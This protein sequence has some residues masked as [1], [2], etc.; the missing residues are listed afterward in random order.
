MASIRVRIGIVVGAVVNR[1][2]TDGSKKEFTSQPAEDKIKP[3]I[4]S[5]EQVRSLP[6]LGWRPL[7]HNT[8]MIPFCGTR[9][10]PSRCSETGLHAR[11]ESGWMLNVPYAG[12]EGPVL[13]F[14]HRRDP[15][16]ELIMKPHKGMKSRAAPESPPR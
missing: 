1:P 10:C 2:V 4:P 11:I 15:Y 7:R 3:S 6:V 5:M 13:G 16:M 12:P 8:D 9:A 14:I